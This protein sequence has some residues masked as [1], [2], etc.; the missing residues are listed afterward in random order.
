MAGEVLS[1]S[2][3]ERLLSMMGAKSEAKNPAETKPLPLKAEYDDEDPE[4]KKVTRE[5]LR[6]LQLMHGG[7]GRRMAAILSQMLRTIVEMRLTCVDRLYYSEFMFGLANPTCYNL[8]NV[9]TGYGEGNMVLDISPALVYP[10]IDR[11]L[12]GGREPALT[13]R[14]PITRI[15]TRLM[16][17]I[18][19]EITAELERVWQNMFAID[20]S[21]AQTESNPRMVQFV[22]DNEGVVVLCF[23]VVLIE[24]R[25]TIAIGIPA[26]LLNQ[27]LPAR[28]CA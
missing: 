22:G 20:I 6:K 27:I 14:R 24:V 4:L 26:N 15:E 2:E 9:V 5:K 17:R 11:L 12:G 3:I 25:G 18:I 1:E 21:L 16:Q 7:F 10:M 19:A 28:V 8:L 13:I 23:E